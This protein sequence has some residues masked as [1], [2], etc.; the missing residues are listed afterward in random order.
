MAQCVTGSPKRSS[1]NKT[2]ILANPV[3]IAACVA[4]VFAGTLAEMQISV[5]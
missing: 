5:V 3:I 2:S 4:P 1:L